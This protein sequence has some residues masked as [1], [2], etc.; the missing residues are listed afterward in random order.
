MARMMA[1]QYV[2]T[3]EGY[4]ARGAYGA[5]DEDVVEV[6][7][8]GFGG[9]GGFGGLGGFGGFGGRFGNVGRRGPSGSA[10]P[11]GGPFGGGGRRMRIRQG[12]GGWVIEVER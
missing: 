12:P 11:F 8:K 9:F 1:S 5:A 4:T 2:R 10:G 6:L 3:R 7:P